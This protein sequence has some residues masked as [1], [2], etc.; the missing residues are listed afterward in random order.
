MPIL[1]IAHI[2]ARIDI[3]AYSR[4]ALFAGELER[5]HKY[6]IKV[7]FDKTNDL[8]LRLVAR[9][10]SPRHTFSPSSALPDDYSLVRIF[11]QE[12]LDDG[13]RPSCR[14]QTLN[15]G[16]IGLSRT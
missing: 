15:S 7:R 3:A 8:L 1:L 4:T 2:S 5:A 10:G 14:V 11:P 12:R 13:G 6:G 9:S 16:V